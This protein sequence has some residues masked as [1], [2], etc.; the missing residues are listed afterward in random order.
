VIRAKLVRE[1]MVFKKSRLCKKVGFTLVEVMVVVGIIGLLALLL[2]PTF[3][4]AR[5]SALRAKCASNLKQLG[6]AVFMYTA[7]HDGN[8]YVPYPVSTVQFCGKQGSGAGIN[9]PIRFLNPYLGGPFQANTTDVLVAR[10]PADKGMP[11]GNNSQYNASGTSYMFNYVSPVV[12]KPTLSTLGQ[13]NYKLINVA[14][15]SKTLMILDQ[16]AFNYYNGGDRK[17]HWHSKNDVRVNACFVDGHVEFI[18]IPAPG[19]IPTYPNTD[20]FTWDP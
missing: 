1:C 11:G 9:N 4:K 20:Q 18:L 6:A 14:Q 19:S 3:N 12:S 10:C 15:H 17:Q 7:D 2:F 5:E 16:A 8:I 13:T